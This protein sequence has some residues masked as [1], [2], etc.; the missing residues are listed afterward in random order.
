MADFTSSFWSWFIGISTILSIVGLL[1]FAMKVGAKKM[2]PGEQAESVGHIWDEDLHELNNPAPRWWYLLFIFSLFWGLLYLFLYPGL[3]SF[4]GYLGWSQVGQYD[5]EVADANEKYGP[6]YDQFSNEDLRSLAENPRAM[7]VGDRLFST[8][9]TTC[10]GSDARGAR[11]FPNL[12]DKDWLYGGDP[13]TIKTSIV[14]G[15]QGIMPPWGSI[16]GDKD[17][18]A[19]AEYIRTL[20]GLA[21]DSGVAA[22]GKVAY[23]QFCVACHGMEG[24]GMQQLGAPDLADDIWLY[25][26]SSKKIIESIKNGRNG[27]M[28]PHHD[29]LGEAKVHILAAYVYSLSN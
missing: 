28:P 22:A 19:I 5:E 15:R 29:F 16:I 8:Y 24:K 7:I 17:I 6:I 18:H 13:D 27:I 4:A 23:S 10:H 20:G 1:G 12:R 26:G 9:C 21:A 25:G 3:G 14:Q 11:G 2:V